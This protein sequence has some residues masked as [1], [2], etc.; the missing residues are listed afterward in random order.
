MLKANPRWCH[1]RRSATENTAIKYE[2][3]FMILV[4]WVNRNSGESELEP[5]QAESEFGRIGIRASDQVRKASGIGEGREAGRP[6]DP[7][8]HDNL[9]EIVL[10]CLEVGASVAY[11]LHE[12]QAVIVRDD[13]D[14]AIQTGDAGT[15]LLVLFADRCS[16]GCD[17]EALRMEVRSPGEEPPRLLG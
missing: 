3:C 6:V 15:A 16:G 5:D 8:L 10:E 7:A 4:R 1:N 17:V 12:P 14:E 2:I 9:Q 13:G 11:V